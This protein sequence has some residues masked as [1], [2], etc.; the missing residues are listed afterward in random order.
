MHR[1]ILFRHGKSAWPH[2]IADHQR[3]LAPRGVDAVPLMARWLAAQNLRPDFALV[4][5]AKRTQGT[6]AL[7]ADVFTELLHRNEPRIYEASAER[8]LGVLREQQEEVRT[9]LM[10]GH[11][12]GMQELALVLSGS[13]QDD[14]EARSRLKRKY[15]TS[16]V[17]VLD[18]E[19]PWRALSPGCAQLVDFVTPAMLGGVDE[20]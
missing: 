2:G 12:P 5:S 18:C 10:V 14:P 7:I 9:L 15:P 4:S 13:E 17:A 8:L 3:P 16:G 20:D 11:N 19:G 6:F 1:L